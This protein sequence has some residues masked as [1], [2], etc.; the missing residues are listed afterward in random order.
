MDFDYGIYFFVTSFNPMV[1]GACIGIGVGF[2]DIDWVIGVIKVYIICVGVGLF[3]GELVDDVVE[4]LVEVGDEF[5]INIGCC[6]WV[7]WFDIVM[8]RYVVWVNLFI[9]LVVVK[10]DVFDVL[11]MLKICVVYDNDGERYEWMFYY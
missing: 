10:F 4:Y 5:G 2:L 9:E 6:C 8:F 7:G 3:L 1:G 11:D